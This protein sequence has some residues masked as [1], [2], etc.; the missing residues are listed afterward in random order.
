MVLPDASGAAYQN[1]G[2]V[3]NRL[4]GLADSEVDARHV[5][6]GNL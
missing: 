6:T 3:K 1:S 2:P 5:G 4:A